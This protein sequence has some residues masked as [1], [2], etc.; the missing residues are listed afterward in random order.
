MLRVEWPKILESVSFFFKEPN[1]IRIISNSLQAAKKNLFCCYS[2]F[3]F[4]I[5]EKSLSYIDDDNLTIAY[6]MNCIHM[7]YL[8]S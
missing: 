1:M 3:Q 6:V 5:T 8:C 2:E 4:I 7:M